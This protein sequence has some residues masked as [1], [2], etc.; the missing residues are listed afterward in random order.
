MCSIQQSCT[1]YVNPPMYSG[2]PSAVVM[3]EKVMQV[4]NVLIK[5]F[6]QDIPLA[7]RA[8]NKRPVCLS[9]MHFYRLKLC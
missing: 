3:G 6:R 2:G 9:T 7:F 4:M 1:N 5:P 8:Q